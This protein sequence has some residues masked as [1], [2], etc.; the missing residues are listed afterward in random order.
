MNASLEETLTSVWR[1]ALV[2]EAQKRDAGQRQ[3]PGTTNEPVEVAR[4][5]LSIRGP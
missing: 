3:F 1:Q 5:G 2:E 4:S